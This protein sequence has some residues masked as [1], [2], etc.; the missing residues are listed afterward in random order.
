MTATPPRNCQLWHPTRGISFSSAGSPARSLR[1]TVEVPVGVS[2]HRFVASQSMA[3]KGEVCPGDVAQQN[4]PAVETKKAEKKVSDDPPP[5]VFDYKIEDNLFYAAKQAAPDSPESY[6]SYTQYRRTTEDGSSQKVRVHYCRSKHTMERICQLYFMDEKV[7]GFDMEWVADATRRDGP[8]KNVS[9]IQLASASRIALFH[10]ALFA[11]SKEPIGESFK[12]IMEDPDVTKVGV[13]IKGDTT[14]LRNFLG[15]QSRG[16]IELSHLY[17]LVTYSRNH[18]YHNINRRLVPLA[19]QVK[20]YLHL[21][22]FKGQDVRSS[23]WS[24]PLGMNQV[25]YSASDAYAGLHLYATFEHYRKQLDP[26]PPTPHHAELNL[27]IQLADGVKISA[28]DDVLEADEASKTNGANPA[29]SERYL[30][31]AF[32]TVSIEDPDV[33]ST[34]A[35]VP[36]TSLTSSASKAKLTSTTSTQKLA[37][38]PKDSRIEV[39]E[40]RAAAFHASHPQARSTLAQLRAYYLW[41]CYDLSPDAIAQLVRDPPLKTATVVQYIF[42]VVQNDSLPVDLDQLRN[43]ASLIPQNI[44]WARWPVVAGRVTD[45]EG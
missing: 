40:D 10:F 1:K 44:L 30:A 27:P 38:H 7:L 26:C 41:H 42:S 43:V 4:T 33:N 28:P 9:L 16:L 35:A 20:E 31:S 15:I 19:T 21:P 29:S 18:Q 25:I 24:K 2:H 13:A 22:L 6:W 14:R 34:P 5:A 11:Y 12:A 3:T 8:K 32:E 36:K 39:A 23:D 17:K 45:A 37:E